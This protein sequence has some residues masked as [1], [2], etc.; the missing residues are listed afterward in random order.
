MEG[1]SMRRLILVAAIALTLLGVAG[2]LRRPA[3]PAP[4]PAAAAPVAATDQLT[5]A[6][7]RA[8]DRLRALPKDWRTWATLASAYVEQARV[9][10]DPT[11]YPKAEGAARQSLSLKASDNVDA[12][13]AFGALANARHD[14]TSARDQARA[15]LALDGY[16][17]EAY[18]VLADA[19]TQ[20]G[21]VSGATEAVQ[22]MLD[23][24]PGLAAY[25]RGSYDLELRGHPDEATDLMR[26]ALA[27]ATDR[28]DIAFCR[29]QLGD[30]AWQRGDLAGAGKEYQAGLAADPTSTALRRGQ[31]RVDTASGKL[32]AALSAYADVTSRAPTPGYLI[33]YAELLRTAGRTDEATAQLDLARAARKLF[34]DNGGVDGLSTASLAI[35]TGHP[36][37]AVTAARAEWARRQ[38]VDVADTLAWALHLTGQDTEAL[39]YAQRVATTGAR[40]ALYAYHLGAIEAALGQRAAARTDLSRALATNPYFPQA[41]DA[42]DLLTK[43]SL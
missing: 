15:A 5:A 41:P 34:T 40:D 11:Y 38:H 18:G 31:A 16:S 22:H 7:N 43:V 10:A 13:I 12:L 26:R 9:T 25:A 6:I 8:Q 19:Q 3:A 29:N 33:E 35:A 17:A 28:H 14:F 30:L 23:L 4:A 32:D 37:D 2:V 36:A 42:R 21:N 1:S 39:G 24:R 27:A 20:L